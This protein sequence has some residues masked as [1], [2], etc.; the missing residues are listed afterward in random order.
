[1]LN[2][3]TKFSTDATVSVVT[4]QGVLVIL[5]VFG[6]G[7][8]ISWEDCPPYWRWLQ[9]CSV[10]TQSSRAVIIAV[11]DQISYNCVLGGGGDC[12]DSLGREYPCSS[13]STVS[14]CLYER[15]RGEK[16][17]ELK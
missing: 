17:L 2:F 14:H 13:Y 9:E 3:I 11:M 7:M 12:Y 6:G 15:E 5:T 10:F 16:T 8:F 4:S 1:M